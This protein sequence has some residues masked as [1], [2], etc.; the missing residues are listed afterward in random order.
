M[1]VRVML[2]DITVEEAATRC[3][4]ALDEFAI[5]APR[6]VAVDHWLRNAY[7][8]ALVGRPAT[9]R[10]PLMPP[11]PVDV[12]VTSAQCQLAYVRRV[13]RASPADLPRELP[14]RLYVARTQDSDGHLGYGPVDGRGEV[15]LVSRVLSL[16]LADYLMRP[17]QYV[18]DHAAVL[19]RSS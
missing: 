1:L 9:W 6:Y 3:R 12:T 19:S 10:A 5:L 8:Q 15:P 18:G 11:L 17:E 4:R 7:Q 16:F 14:P 13:A 2:D